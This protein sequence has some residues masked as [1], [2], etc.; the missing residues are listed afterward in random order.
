MKVIIIF[1][2]SLLSLFLSFNTGRIFFLG[3]IS[4]RPIILLLY[5]VTLYW[6][7]VYALFMGF[8]IGFLYETSFPVF[9]G[10]FPLIFTS[11]VFILKAIERKVFKLR[12]NSLFL[13]F[14]A[15]LFVGI[16]QVVI[17][18]DRVEPIFY[19]VFTRLIP[20]AIFNTAVGF[21]ILYFIKRCK[22]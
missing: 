7:S 20:E 12:Y 8:F 6:N 11:F 18:V 4:L 15:L 17:E 13:L 2:L 9:T 14:C 19:I 21:V 5:F 22:R 1:I 10:T 3:N 16:L